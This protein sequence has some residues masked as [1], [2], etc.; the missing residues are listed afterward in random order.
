MDTPN[1]TQFFNRLRP[2]LQG[3]G[4]RMLGSV[5]D[6]EELVQDVWLRWHAAD[7]NALDNAEA[8]LVTVTSRLAIDR[9]RSA[10]A[11]RAH[12]TGFWLPEPWL[13][14]DAHVAGAQVKP[15]PTPEELLEHADDVSVAFLAL[16]ERLGPE[17]RL[18]FLLREIFDADYAQVAQAL[19]KSEAACRQIVSRAKS[20]LRDGRTRQTVSPDTHYRLLTS[21]AQAA[22]GG[23]VNALQ[24]LL[25]E[26]AELVSDGGGVVPSFGKVLHG[27]RRITALYYAG[28]RRSQRGEALQ[29]LVLARM[30]GSWGMLRFVDG[31]LESVHS[32]QTDGQRIVRIQVQRNPD[33]LHR[34]AVEWAALEALSQPASAERLGQ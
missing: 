15:P 10:K 31:Q 1:P 9:L 18:A 21:F 29:R 25:D 27:G 4:Y 12:Y 23:D 13:D 7:V 11:Q 33:K 24:T 8:W 32:P 34:I 22:R 6:A 2:R 3:I 30:N 17:A 5:A 19:G 16:L 28:W 26:H 14:A 20:Q